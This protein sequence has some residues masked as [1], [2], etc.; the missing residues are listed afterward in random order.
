MMSFLFGVVACICATVG[1]LCLTTGRPIMAGFEFALAATA[2]V[3]Y[4][5]YRW[6][7]E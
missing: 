6:R 4:A 5:I 7:R 2:L 3:D 1:A